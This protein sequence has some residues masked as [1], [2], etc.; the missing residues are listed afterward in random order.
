VLRPTL[1]AAVLAGGVAASGFTA[2]RPARPVEGY[3]VTQRV[4][5]AG[6]TQPGTMR[7]KTAQ[8]KIR[9]E[10][11]GIDANMPAGVYM[12]LRD[13]GRMSV[14]M[15]AEKRVMVMDL[16]AMTSGAGALGG[17]G[18]MEFK[19]VAVEVEDLGAGERLLGH[20][21]HKYRVTQR[22]T[23]AMSMMGQSIQTTNASS[24][25][26]WMAADVPGADAMA[27]FTES[28]GGSMTGGAPAAKPLADAMKGKMPKGTALK[29]VATMTVT[30]N[31]GTPT[32]TVSTVE[33]T[34]ITKTDIDPA[35]FESPAG[36]EVM[37]LGDMM[38]KLRG[39]IDTLT[40]RR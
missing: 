11:E 1:L 27:K 24:S 18:A 8:G 30:Q 21:T 29:T 5:T 22:Y 4:T 37:D 31:S 25:E 7:I 38:A 16:A 26:V 13:D 23:I 39:M 28:I 32:T 14:V 2:A 10:V 40:S 12:L 34:A 33:V 19:D 6:E 15:P 3:V 9:I 20:A 35:E 17:M 36:Y